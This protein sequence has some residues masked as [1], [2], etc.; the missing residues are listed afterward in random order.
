MRT[1]LFA[2]AVLLLV[3]IGGFYILNAYIY[4][5]KQADEVLVDTEAR[6]VYLAQYED[7][8][9]NIAFDYPAGPDGYTVDD[10]TALAGAEASDV[11]LVQVLRI[12]NTNEK[13]ELENSE[14][15]REGLP[16]MQ[17]MV[18]RNTRNQSASMWVDAFPRFSN[19]E[20][21][22]G[23]VNRD[24]VVGGANAVRYTT[25]GLYVT[26]MVAVASGEFI[27]L[28]SGAYL[29]PDSV[30]HE[31]FKAL[32]DSVRFIP[33]DGASAGVGA[34]IDVRVACESALAYM[35]FETGEES[36]QFVSECIAGEHPEV[37]ERY[38]E[39]LGLDGAAV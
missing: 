2:F 11:E 25:D 37:I 20:L 16:A 17:L 7:A 19:I 23:E 29:E 34:K 9:T 18:F 14:G 32:V 39:S 5:A 1:L 3:I 33:A 35:M 12:M 6:D 27:Y 26:D 31:D 10:L 38:I 4:H 13:Y 21:L 36:E 15:G 30:I 22:L 8:T 24:A 28:F